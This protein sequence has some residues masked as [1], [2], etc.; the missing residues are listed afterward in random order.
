MYFQ[1]LDAREEQIESAQR[2]AGVGNHVPSGVHVMFRI[3][4]NPSLG[5]GRV[6]ISENDDICPGA[7]TCVGIV[8]KFVSESNPPV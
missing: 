1:P 7:W 6:E 5:N 2:A 3:H 4:K 8:V